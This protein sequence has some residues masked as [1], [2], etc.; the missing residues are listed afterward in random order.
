MSASPL[1]PFCPGAPSKFT[2]H[3]EYDEFP[4]IDCNCIFKIP[5]VYE[6][7]LPTKKSAV[8]LFAPKITF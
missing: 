5:D 1:S 3:T 8:S 6:I 4:L 2:S 7:T